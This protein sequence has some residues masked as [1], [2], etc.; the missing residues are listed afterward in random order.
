MLS[1]ILRV[2]QAISIPQLSNPTEA[3]SQL[4]TLNNAT[5]G[6][7]SPE[8]RFHTS[9]SIGPGFLPVNS[10]LL[11]ALSFLADMSSRDHD[12]IVPANIWV[13]PGAQDVRITT[14][15][16][17]QAKYLLWGVYQGLEYMIHN[18]R[19]NEA[20]LT[21]K[22]DQEIVGRIW[23]VLA[24]DPLLGL[25]SNHSTQS[26]TQHRDHSWTALNITAGQASLANE[27]RNNT[28]LMGDQIKVGVE[29]IR[30]AV[31]LTRFDVFLVCYAAL[32]DISSL[33]PD[34]QLNDFY[35]KS[36]LDKVFIKI[37]PWRPSVK[38]GQVIGLMEFIP[39]AMLNS[40]NGFRE[41][42]FYMNVGEHKLLE[43]SIVKGRLHAT[44]L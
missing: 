1:I 15:D 6:S 14:E 7:D 33:N 22:L 37:F 31:R 36:P 23:I 38:I 9:T 41:V 13:A 5:L 18:K 26:V 21:L 25:A 3:T 2:T 27:N 11:N 29:T 42:T 19:F 44:P 8:D 12:E 10:T 20:L 34:S 17:Y 28:I 39:R 16:D 24:S 35:S 40:E 4:L 43:G 32:V 30:N